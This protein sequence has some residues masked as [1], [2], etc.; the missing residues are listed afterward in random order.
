MAAEW[1]AMRNYS[2]FLGSLRANGQEGIFALLL[3]IAVEGA[4][5]KV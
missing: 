2:Q 5:K 1:T 3:Y 4:E